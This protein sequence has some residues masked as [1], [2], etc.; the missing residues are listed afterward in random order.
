MSRMKDGTL[1]SL[2]LVSNNST[3]GCRSDYEL[4]TACQHNDARAFAALYRRYERYVHGLIYQ[5]APDWRNNREDMTQEVFIKVWRSIAGLKNPKA[6]K[7]WLHQLLTN[8]FYDELRKRPRYSIVSMDEPGYGDDEFASKTRDIIDESG[9]PDELAQNRELVER[10]NAAI[11][12][13][14]RQFQ[15]VIV[16]REVHGLTYETIAQLTKTEVGT[17]KSRIARARLKIQ[18]QLADMECA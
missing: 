18:N 13:L 6:F 11:A 4:V 8:L 9:M 3:Y 17:V 7:S 2:R 12:R 14:P 10:I 1:P 5:M 16:L 15:N